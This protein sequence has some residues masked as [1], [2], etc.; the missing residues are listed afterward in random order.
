MQA[1]GNV[2]RKRIA[3]GSKSERDA[4]L[5]QTRDQEYVLRIVGANPFQDPRLDALVGKRIC[6]QGDVH[7]NAF[8]MTEWREDAAR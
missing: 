1:T 8:L 5:L 2:I 6:A 7:G 4:V 3:I